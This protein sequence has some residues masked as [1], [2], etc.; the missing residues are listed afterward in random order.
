MF[1]HLS[2]TLHVLFERSRAPTIAYVVNAYGFSLQM[3]LAQC[4]GKKKENRVEG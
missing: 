3:T 1:H 2:D 4:W